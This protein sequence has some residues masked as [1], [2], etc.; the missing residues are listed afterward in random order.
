MRPR[1]HGQENLQVPRHHMFWYPGAPL[2]IQGD[3]KMS[4]GDPSGAL[5]NPSD[6][7]SPRDFFRHPWDPSG[8]QGIILGAQE[9]PSEMSL[10]NRGV[11][12][13]F[14]TVHVDMFCLWQYFKFVL[15][16]CLTPIWNLHS[17]SSICSY[18]ALLAAYGRALLSILHRNK[19][20][21]IS[22]AV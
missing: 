10:G 14:C 18:L 1:K 13:Q 12:L 5:G 2:R 6:A 21:Y 19:V 15:F 7:Q 16:F 20:F 4:P 9:T 22:P 11:P 3:P 8:T 17:C